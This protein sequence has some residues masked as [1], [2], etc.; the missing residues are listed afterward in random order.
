MLSLFLD[1]I[2][3]APLIGSMLMCFSAAFI[4]GVVFLRKQSLVGEALSHAAYPGVI[5]GMLCAGISSFIPEESEG[6]V[7]LAL[8]V[9]ASLTAY[10]GLW[11]I[12]W[13]E[14]TL[15]IRTDSALC[16]VLAT[17][18]GVGLTLASYLQFLFPGLYRKGQAYLYGQAAT[19]TDVN[20]YIYGFFALISIVVL[21]V[22]AKELQTVI[23]S[24]EYA[25]S[26]GIP[27]KLIQNCIML[28]LLLAVVIGIR[29][30]GVVLMSA[31]LIAPASSARQFTNRFMPML[32]LSGC[33]GMISAFLGVLFS[34]GISHHLSQLYPGARLSIPTGPMIVLVASSI[35]LLALFFAPERGIIRR[36]IR[37][38]RFRFRCLCENML[39]A[40]WRHSPDQPMSW[41]AI[42][43]TQP[44]DR[45]LL[46]MA[47]T[48]LV[49]SG[50]LESAAQDQY[51]LT[52]DGK[53]RAARIV[54]LHRLWE[55]YLANYLGVGAERV[56]KNA[57]EMEHIL[58]PEL[59]KE[60]TRLLKDPLEDPHHQKIPRN[61]GGLTLS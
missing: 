6:W 43:K 9:G 10:A 55:V 15:R 25:K 20:I 54:R 1:P 46:W 29:S 7:T 8:M 13:M 53:L 49:R 38:G 34:D 28:L 35:C 27:V 19:M 33:F 16:F 12:H 41:Q 56:H 58:N 3:R 18:F 52:S 22:F 26:I 21:S 24:S 31:M 14:R 60:L 37:I 4:G 36:I 30:V 47:R 61:E 2:L 17:F 23:F 50:W 32:W 45:L 51:Q 42:A 44:D 59:E 57:E 39:K 11:V 5:L 40:I 48:H